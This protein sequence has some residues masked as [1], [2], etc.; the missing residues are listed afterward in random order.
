[1]HKH[2][3]SRRSV[4][5]LGLCAGAALPLG[6]AGFPPAQTRAAMKSDAVSA[7]E[8]LMREHGALIRL[9]LVYREAA[10]QLE[11]GGG[12]RVKEVRAAAGIIRRFIEDYH[13]KIEEKFV[14]PRLEK[15]PDLAGLV[16]VLRE[17]HEAG[18]RVTDRL[19]ELAGAELSGGKRAE[20]GRL[21]DTFSRMYYPHLAREDTVLFPAY[22][23]SLSVK[24]YAT[25]GARF[26][27]LEHEILGQGGFENTLAG[28]ETLERD[29]G[30]DDLTR[31]TPAP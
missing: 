30:I 18:R 3:I 16:R 19:L 27:D 9:L 6:L 13:E 2:W 26:E 21:I 5:R 4:L 1:M 8:D 22:R 7:N 24:E 11:S 10:T 31:F 12:G 15:S 25:M 14:F 29:L 17:Q 28:I 20:A 23:A